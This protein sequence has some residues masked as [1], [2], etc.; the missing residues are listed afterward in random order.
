MNIFHKGQKVSIPIAKDGLVATLKQMT[1]GLVFPIKV[2]GIALIDALKYLR[3]GDLS[4]FD[5][6]M[7]MVRHQNIGIEEKGITILVAL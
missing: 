7:N 6:E 1:H 2:H 3:E 4:H 5:Q